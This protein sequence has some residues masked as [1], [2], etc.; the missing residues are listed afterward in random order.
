MKKSLSGIIEGFFNGKCNVFE[1]VEYRDDFGM[2]QSEEKLVLENIPCRVCY[3]N[4]KAAVKGKVSDYI[5]QKV[6]LMVAA[7]I[8]V[9]NGSVIE[10]TQNGQTALYQKTG[11]AAVYA[12]HREIEMSLKNMFS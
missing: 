8:S 4:I 9:K 12:N 3:K 1:F 6:T 10:V 2:V 5:T 11:E 7:D